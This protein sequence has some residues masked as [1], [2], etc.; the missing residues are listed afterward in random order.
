[1]AWVVAAAGDDQADDC[2][3]GGREAPR[4]A[5][6][7]AHARESQ[8]ISPMKP[9]EERSSGRA[10]EPFWR[11]FCTGD[12]SFSPASDPAAEI[13]PGRSPTTTSVTWKWVGPG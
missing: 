5:L 6:K 8:T 13:R 4:P 2:R 11:E 3:R 7:R 10:T 9:R 12:A 1:M